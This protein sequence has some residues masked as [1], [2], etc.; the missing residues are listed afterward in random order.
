MH[1]GTGREGSVTPGV[2][3]SVSSQGFTSCLLTACSAARA[4]PS[5]GNSGP[6]TLAPNSVGTAPLLA[7]RG[8]C[9]PCPFSHLPASGRRFSRPPS[10]PRIPRVSPALETFIALFP[11][12]GHVSVPPVLA[13]VADRGQ[14]KRHTLKC[15]SHPEQNPNY[16]SW[17]PVLLQSVTYLCWFLTSVSFP[18]PQIVSCIRAGTLSDTEN[19]HQLP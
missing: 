19:P 10:V 13:P 5:T 12:S 7:P 4:Q 11:L 2:T 15:P 9:P 6:A 8:P 3:V 17:Q 1:E 16:R 14:R 18:L